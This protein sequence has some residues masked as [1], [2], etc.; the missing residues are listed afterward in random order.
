MGVFSPHCSACCLYYLLCIKPLWS[1]PQQ[2]QWQQLTHWLSGR[3]SR[4]IDFKGRKHIFWLSPHLSLSN[5][6]FFFFFMAIKLAVLYTSP[7]EKSLFGYWTTLL[8]SPT[9]KANNFEPRDWATRWWE[10]NKKQ[11]A[12]RKKNYFFFFL[13]FSCLSFSGCV[14]RVIVPLQLFPNVLRY[15][16]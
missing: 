16:D 11:Q 12:K 8:N 15:F 4:K 1:C 7:G 9:C 6:R 5:S 10:E 14:A 13:P 2:Q 3:W